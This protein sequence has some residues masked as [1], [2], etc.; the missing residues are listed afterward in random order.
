MN[1]MW[2]ASMAAVLG[3][4]GW[5]GAV[6]AWALSSTGPV[7]AIMGEE[8]FLG[9]ATGHLDGSGTM[10]IGSQRNP[11]LTC[12]GEFTSSA[13]LGGRG[14]L[15]CSNGATG[16]YRFKRLTLRK[17]YGAG[18]Y[19]RRPMNFTYGLTAE[20]SAPYLKLPSGKKL[21]LR[22]KA[23]VLVAASPK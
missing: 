8:L 6:D 22:G 10:T 5:A 13:K 17:G 20:E 9:E 3:A 7:I 2:I 15:R 11:G 4:A 18:S 14:R 1:R 16:T 23:P 12:R 21:D 19:A